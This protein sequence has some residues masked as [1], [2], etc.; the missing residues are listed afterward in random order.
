[1]WYTRYTPATETEADYSLVLARPNVGLPC[2]DEQAFP[3]ITRT[4]LCGDDATSDSELPGLVVVHQW[5]PEAAAASS[6]A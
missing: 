3:T 1:M 4:S 6:S 2:H 5:G